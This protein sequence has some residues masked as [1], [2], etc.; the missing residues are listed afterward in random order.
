MAAIS[1]TDALTRVAAGELLI[2]V[3]EQD[4]WDSGHAPS[5]RLLPL[6]VLAERLGELPADTALLV[7]CH[8]GGRSER[9]CNFL[10]AH[11]YDVTNVLGGMSAWAAA[12]GPVVAGEDA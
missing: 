10:A 6:S 9:A 4:E 5:A 7:I 12:G 11:G 1:V 2:D 8:S 3:R